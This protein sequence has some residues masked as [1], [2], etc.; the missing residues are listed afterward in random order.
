MPQ[1]IHNRRLVVFGNSGS[2]KSTLARRLSVSSELAHLD[3]DTLAWNSGEPPVRAP[4]AQSCQQIDAFTADN[5]AWVIEGCYADLLKHAM[6]SATEM[7]FLDAGLAQCEQNAKRRGFEPHKYES[8]EAQD[9]NLSM[10]IDWIGAY[11]SRDDE[12]SHAAHKA[13][14][15]SFPGTKSRFTRNQEATVYQ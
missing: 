4:L 12:F 5:A 6:C 3:L 8:K 10:L 14:F 13:L 15:E 1:K 2:G 9:A 11:Y 7:V